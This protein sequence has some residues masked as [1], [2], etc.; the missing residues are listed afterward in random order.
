MNT[1]KAV[2]GPWLPAALAMCAA[3]AFLAL[4][5]APGAAVAAALATGLAVAAWISARRQGARVQEELSELRANLQ[6]T[7]TTLQEA[8]S[9][10]M[11]L[12]QQVQAEGERME[13]CLGPALATLESAHQGRQAMR[14]DIATILSMVGRVNVALEQIAAGAASQA[15]DLGSTSQLAANLSQ[16][17]SA[18]VD[19]AQGLSQA[20]Q[21]S[22]AAVGEGRQ[23]VTEVATAMENVR[24]AVYR[25]SDEIGALGQKSAQISGIL[26]VISDIANQ[27]NLLALNAAIE[28][29]RA[30]EHGRGFAVVAD[31]VRRLAETSNRSTKQIEAII[32]TISQSIGGAVKLMEHCTQ[33]TEE[34]SQ[35]AARAG[36][37]LAAIERMANQT[38]SMAASMTTKSKDSSGHIAALFEAITRAAAV[39]Q[40]NSATTAD[41]AA[42]NWFSTA[43]A[44][45]AGEADA[46]FE[47]I[48][49]LSDRLQELTGPGLAGPSRH[50][51]YSGAG[52]P[53][54]RAS[55]PAGRDRPMMAGPAK[56]RPGTAAKQRLSTS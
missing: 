6:A 53:R 36:H 43:L 16:F 18:A 13:S 20:A 39:T 19:E 37:A 42:Q 25:S 24:K 11:A 3:T 17:T 29:A 55:G 34:G 35:L 50:G 45:F 38:H 12:R 54:G 9:G 15:A 46:L 8:E 51:Q 27:T 21:S 40:E 22:L 4:F 1:T 47:L 33:A 14:E 48:D 26:A 31:E 5:W 30:G 44:N 2:S 28:A 56:A 52:L 7:G 41:L 32:S 23:A 10:I 49:A